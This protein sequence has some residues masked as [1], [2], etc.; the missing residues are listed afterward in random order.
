M[1][2]VGLL[3]V[4]LPVVPIPAQSLTIPVRP[5]SARR[6]ESPAGNVNTVGGQATQP[7]QKNA[8]ASEV[9][10][11]APAAAATSIPG[12]GN[13]AAAAIPLQE[14]IENL[15]QRLSAE[16]IEPAANEEITKQLA[17]IARNAQLATDDQTALAAL[18]TRLESLNAEAESLQKPPAEPAAGADLKTQ[19]LQQL[20]ALEARLQVQVT[21]EQQKLNAAREYASQ[22]AAN[23]QTLQQE[24]VQV[25]TTIGELGAP[26]QPVDLATA[27]R[28]MAI[29]YLAD[30]A[31]RARLAAQQNLLQARLSLVDAEQKLSLPQLRVTAREAVVNRLSDELKK[32]RAEIQTRNQT[33]MQEKL[34]QAQLAEQRNSDTVLQAIA[35]RN[36]ELAEQN[37]ELV[38]HLIPKWE[39]RLEERRAKLTSTQ[40]E[41]EKLQGRITRFGAE[42]GIGLELLKFQ[43]GLPS[44]IELR[45][46]LEETETEQKR[47]QRLD[48]QT[49][50]KLCKSQLNETQSAVD[51][52]GEPDALEIEKI[53]LLKTQVEFLT[54]QIGHNDSL[55]FVLSDLNNECRSLVAATEHWTDFIQQH[56]LW[57]PTHSWLQWSDLDESVDELAEV[58]VKLTHEWSEPE[59]AER[60]S[61]I[62]F[63]LPALIALAALGAVQRKARRGIAECSEKAARR[64]CIYIT[65]T[66]RTIVL[67]LALSATWPVVIVLAGTTIK[68]YA[69]NSEVTYAL[70]HGLVQL[71]LVMLLLNFMRQALRDDGLTESHFQ[72]DESA[73]LAIRAWLHRTI[74]MI[75]L[76][77]M[78][79]LW[80]RNL[81]SDEM[82]VPR[83]SFILLMVVMSILLAQLLHPYRSIPTA[84]VVSRV[85]LI[86]R[87]RWFWYL[88]ITLFPAALA[89]LS[90]SGYHYS[91]VALANR[92]AQSLAVTVLFILLYS[93]LLRWLR[94]GRTRAHLEL[95]RERAAQ[96]AASE[97]AGEQSETVDAALKAAL[98]ENQDFEVFGFHARS[99]VR[100]LV[101]IT[102]APVLWGIWVEVLPAL[103]GFSEYEVWSVR[104]EVT[105]VDEQSDAQDVPPTVIRLR[106]V[107]VGNVLLAG[108]ISVATFVGVRHLPGFVEVMILNRIA[109]E[110]GVRYAITTIIRYVLL[111]TGFIVV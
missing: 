47:L 105:T 63:L 18:R 1:W 46:L 21:D 73:C 77:L 89:V 97:A 87:T 83:L 67:T 26:G 37:S 84:Y 70:G 60:G 3:L 64:S 52:S 36:T 7:P 74:L 40:D 12:D 91:S 25:G 45:S 51:E 75:C 92:L 108:L 61:M 85:P 103:R 57:I 109:F 44:L 42:G 107:T 71:G 96:R 9:Q 31:R 81:D 66:I 106:A 111:L 76:P 72:W 98:P 68:F 24:L 23:R 90:A 78:A 62:P 16:G 8:S 5:T 56:A 93:F 102:L 19:E 30:Q 38:N 2:I 94:V 53:D 49:E 101:I 20:N 79:F 95:A 15:R 28:E 10:D 104:E 6:Q 58:T 11:P 27:P 43:K 35:R 22:A 65:P 29:Q 48:L 80:L 14:R 17:D 86:R 69:S 39:K 41:G 100:G 33:A 34:E 82:A 13:P 54:S 55:F 59:R 50:L 32:V 99:L 110:P 4:S 88:P